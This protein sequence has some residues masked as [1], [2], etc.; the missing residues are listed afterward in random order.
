MRPNQRAAAGR[1]PS[2]GWAANPAELKDQL[3]Q[4]NIQRVAGR[5]ILRE[6]ASSD[7]TVP[8]GTDYR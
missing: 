5:A 8:R 1:V 2:L 4:T 6:T 7:T 3:E